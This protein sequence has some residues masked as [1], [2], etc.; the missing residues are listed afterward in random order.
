V[1]TDSW[2]ILQLTPASGW[3]ARFKGGAGEL[4]EDAL[5]SW[6][7]VEDGARTFVV[8]MTASGEGPACKFA[9][10]DERFAG[11]FFRGAQVPVA[12]ELPT[13]QKA[14]KTGLAWKS[15]TRSDGA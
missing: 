7:L 13:A 6:A 15:T 12:A 14:A 11:Y 2:K 3:V 9:P 8:G 4:S 10:R 5:A 1:N